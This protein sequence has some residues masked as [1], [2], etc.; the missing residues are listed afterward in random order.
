MNLNEDLND[1]NQ[2]TEPMRRINSWLLGSASAVT[3]AIPLRLFLRRHR[4]PRSL[5]VPRI[6]RRP[7]SSALRWSAWWGLGVGE[8]RGER[9]GCNGELSNLLHGPMAN[10]MQIGHLL[11][12]A[13][14]D[15]CSTDLATYQK[16]R[17]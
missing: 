4:H 16:L 3:Q 12:K 9:N 10:N 5:F 7:R 6:S 13:G 11:R 8:G 1:Y 15:C 2:A 17:L 14:F